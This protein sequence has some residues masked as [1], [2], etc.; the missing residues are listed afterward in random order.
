MK[1]LFLFSVLLT[2]AGTSLKA[3]TSFEDIT[4]I[5]MNE[6]ETRKVEVYKTGDN[7][8]EGKVVWLKEPNG[9]YKE[10]DIVIKDLTYADGSFKNGKAFAAG[11]WVNCQAR[12]QNDSTLKLTAT[13]MVFSKSKLYYR[14]NK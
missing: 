3:Q 9:T 2:L 13:K 14:V 7:K 8:Y 6:S 1:R 12:L 4:G 5:W 11:S 10:G